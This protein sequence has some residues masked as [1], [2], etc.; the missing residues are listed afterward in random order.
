VVN[1]QNYVFYFESDIAKVFPFRPTCSSYDSEIKKNKI[2]KSQKRPAKK[3][4]KCQ[5]WINNVHVWDLLI[6]V[7]VRVLCILKI[8][9][10]CRHCHLCVSVVTQIRFQCCHCC[11]VKYDMIKKNPLTLR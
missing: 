1:T 10:L 4:N 6:L 7:I 3:V 2:T 11:D 5:T 9:I 8:L